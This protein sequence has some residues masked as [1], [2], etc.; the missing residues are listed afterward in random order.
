MLRLCIPSIFSGRRQMKA[1]LFIALMAV[2]ILV[3]GCHQEDGFFVARAGHYKLNEDIVAR[4][5]NPVEYID[6]WVEIRLLAL[7]AERQGLDENIEFEAQIESIRAKLLVE[8]LLTQQTAAIQPPGEQEIENY[9]QTHIEEFRRV[10]PEVEF[11]SFSGLDNSVLK[12]VRRSLN[13]GADIEGV[14]EKYPGLQYEADFLVDPAS[15]SAPF[16]SMASASPGSV[17]GPSN[18]GGRQYVFKITA[19]SQA[20]TVKPL[21]DVRQVINDRFLKNRRLMIRER[22]LKEL[23]EKYKPEV[24]AERLKAAGIIN[25]EE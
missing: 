5:A 7:E 1:L 6:N 3:N 23:R 2:L 20:G 15:M 8:M 9:Y 4:S 24:N 21:S 18:I 14:I 17:I 11:V 25:G 19:K 12:E 16:S 22:L 13:R 10:K